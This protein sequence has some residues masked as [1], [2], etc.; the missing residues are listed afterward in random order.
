MEA[1]PLR[2][3]NDTT[4]SAYTFLSLART[5]A[6]RAMA[7]SQATALRKEGEGDDTSFIRTVSSSIYTAVHPMSTHCLVQE[8]VV[9]LLCSSGDGA[10]RGYLAADGFGSQFC[11]LEAEAREEVRQCSLSFGT[12]I[13]PE[14]YVYV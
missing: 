2:M 7:E 14:L 6:K 4:S 8:D 12:V 11:Y 1:N 9:C 13:L 5:R 3:R 10:K